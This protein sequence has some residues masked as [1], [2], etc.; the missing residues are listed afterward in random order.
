MQYFISLSLKQISSSKL[1]GHKTRS[2][3]KGNKRKSFFDGKYVRGIRGM[4]PLHPTLLF[5]C[6][7]HPFQTFF[8]LTNIQNKKWLGISAS[9]L[10][11]LVLITC[12]FRNKK[13]DYFS[14]G[15]SET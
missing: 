9:N 12:L 2:S 7:F 5:V 4:Q 1:E 6:T 11:W 10:N 15:T 3:M 13:N 14:H 8:L